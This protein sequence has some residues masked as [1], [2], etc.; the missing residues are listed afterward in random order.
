MCR[1][2]SLRVELALLAANSW[3]RRGAAPSRRAAPL[4]VR[5]RTASS[6][7]GLL[8]PE[9]AHLERQKDV[10]EAPEQR[11]EPDPDQQEQRPR[12]KLLLGDPEAEQDLQHARDH[13]QPPGWVDLPR[14]GGRDKADAAPEDPQP[15]AHLPPLPARPP[16]PRPY[17]PH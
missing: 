2:R 14:E 3:G 7:C 1:A 17:P 9:V 16:T 13:A 11:E 15:P 5:L 6:D 8:A 4:T 12:G 10:G